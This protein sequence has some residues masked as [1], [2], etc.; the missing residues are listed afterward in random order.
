MTKIRDTHGFPEDG[1]TPDFV[2][3]FNKYR[4]LIKTALE[5][6]ESSQITWPKIDLNIKRII[7][8]GDGMADNPSDKPNPEFIERIQKTRRIVRT[9][10]I[11]ITVLFP[12]I[13][14]MKRP[15]K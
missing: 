10:L 11:A 15:I 12:M 3:N 6:V 13:Q 2:I 14:M 1:T 4:P 8:L 9:F 7:A 5:F